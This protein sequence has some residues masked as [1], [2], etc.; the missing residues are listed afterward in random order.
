MNEKMHKIVELIPSDKQ[1]IAHVILLEIDFLS[2]TMQHLKEFVDE[3]GP[4]DEFRQGKQQF[5]RESPALKSYNTCVARYAQL[6]KQ[7]AALI[8]EGSADAADE[9]DEFLSEG[10]HINLNKD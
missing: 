1:E 6:L 5:L 10:M 2:I 8:P 7:L 9:L 3:H 4:V